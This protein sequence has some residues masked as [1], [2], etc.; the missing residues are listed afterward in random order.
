MRTIPELERHAQI[1]DCLG[2]AGMSSD[3]TS[4]EGG[5]KMYRVKKKFWRAAELGPFLHMIDRI[6]EQTK[7]A[8]SSKGSTKYLR[9]PGK[10]T[11]SEGGVVRG[12]PINF[13]D[14]AWLANLQTNMKP[15]FDSLKINF[16]PYPLVH[17]ETIQE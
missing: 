8:T 10:D 1:L 5:V 13:Y 7:N 9:L 4:K 16:N 15:V 14:T 17:D 3:E 12:L 11:S 6:T 2:C